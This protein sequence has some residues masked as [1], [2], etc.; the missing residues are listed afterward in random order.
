MFSILFSKLLATL[1]AGALLASG[2]PAVKSFTTFADRSEEPVS[3]TGSL[4]D[5]TVELESGG[6]A[7]YDTVEGAN[8]KRSGKTVTVA[9]T[10]TLGGCQV[11]YPAGAKITLATAKSDSDCWT[12]VGDDG[13][14]VLSRDSVTVTG[15]KMRFLGW[16]DWQTNGDGKQIGA[17]A[18][19]TG[20]I[21]GVNLAKQA[22]GSAYTDITGESQTQVITMPAHAAT[23]YAVWADRLI[24]GGA[25]SETDCGDLGLNQG[26]TI[27]SVNAAY[28][29]TASAP[30]GW[31]K[32]DA[33]KKTGYLFDHWDKKNADGT[34]TEVN[35]NDKLTEAITICPAFTPISYKVG[36][37]AHGG[38]G[39]MDDQSFQYD[40]AQELTANTFTRVGYTFTGWN[41][42]AD[43]KGKAYND[44][45]KVTNLVNTNG[46]KIT[47]YAQWQPNEAGLRYHAN[48]GTGADY[49]V[50]G[51]TDASLTVED[52]SKFTR[53]GYTFTGWKRD[54]ATTGAD[55]NARDMIT[56]DAD[57]VDLYAQW[58]ANPA[59]ILYDANH[60][61][62]TGSTDTQTGET[63]GDVTIQNNGFTLNGY[64]FTGW[65]TSPDG[66]NGNSYAAE[67]KTKYPAGETT[68]YAQWT[69]NTATILYDAN[70]QGATG[71]TDKQTGKTDGDVTIQ[72]N[73]FTLN[74]YTFTGWNTSP[75]GKNGNSYAAGQKTK[76][77]AG[78]T[79]LY[80]QW[81]A[82]PSRITYDRNADSI[83]NGTV[84]G[85]TADTTGVTD[86]QVN[87][88]EN[89]FQAS[90]YRFKEW[91]TKP[92]GTGTK[93][94]EK[95]AFTL[96]N[97]GSVTLYAIW[98][99]MSLSM[100][101]SGGDGL[102]FNVAGPLTIAVI[103]LVAGVAATQIQKR[104][105]ASATGRHATISGPR[106]K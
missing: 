43:G 50:S 28:G 25:Q 44:R 69:P 80:A 23:V 77:P 47:L 67:Q 33:D 93:Y 78:E 87:V 51:A 98:Q 35:W 55:V 68:L 1:T 5:R 70:H 79:T 104:R 88:A 39:T 101:F 18:T 99:E 31:N 92:D 32:G 62:A 53:D 49:T 27:P 22:N 82:N 6:I 100:P 54:N 73:G 81:K 95:A 52:G 76:Y 26:V 24:A 17:P 86:Q 97:T 66:K 14:P 45:Q 85:S 57:G 40:E 21:S 2:M 102:G 3:K 34:Y 60:Q 96:P 12:L 63:D 7:V 72:N 75:D 56:L 94:A 65:N 106:H 89:G 19:V 30:A 64:T 83:P 58:K 74:G 48:G 29:E 15:Q 20:N 13:N 11:Y 71:S 9:D 36:F 84:S 91:N 90:G 38:T 41:T 8:L 103:A 42:Q 105:L 10:E 16:S 61:G 37:D 59:T 46:G 4:A